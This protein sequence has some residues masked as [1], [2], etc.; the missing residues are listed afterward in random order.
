[1]LY[2]LIPLSAAVVLPTRQM[3]AEFAA[4]ALPLLIFAGSSGEFAQPWPL[5]AA[6][7]FGLALRLTRRLA[8]K[9]MN[10][11]YDKR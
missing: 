6:F 7:T 3:V 1:M 9:S 5:L 11:P 8:A 10:T 4:L 2:Y